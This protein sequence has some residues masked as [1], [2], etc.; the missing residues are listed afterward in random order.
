MEVV[1][2]VFAVELA[3]QIV[4][5]ADE[6]AL[7]SSDEPANW[8]HPFAVLSFAGQNLKSDDFE[9]PSDTL[10]EIF[11]GDSLLVLKSFATAIEVELLNPETEL[12]VATVRLS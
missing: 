8:S 3:L 2:L 5:A 1:A 12:E 7:R 9:I 10:R 6:P 4:A 11:R